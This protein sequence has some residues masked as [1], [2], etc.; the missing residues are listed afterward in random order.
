M[1]KKDK[2]IQ[3]KKEKEAKR[4][5]LL[6]A[7]AKSQLTQEQMN[8]LNSIKDATS[9]KRDRKHSVGNQIEEEVINDNKEEVQ[10]EN[11]NI[12]QVNIFDTV[13]Y[14]NENPIQIQHHESHQKMS[15]AERLE[16][17]AKQLFPDISL[18]SFDQKRIPKGQVQAQPRELIS[19]YDPEK[20]DIYDID[21]Q[22]ITN[23]DSLLTDI[24]S[25]KNQQINRDENIIK[26]RAQ[27]P[28]LI[29]ENDII[30]AI[31]GNLIT[32]ISGETGCGKSTQIPQFLYEAGFT[33][34]GAIAITQPRRLA[35]ISL[36]QRVRDETGFTMGKEISYQVKHECSGID[37]DKMKMK[38][39]TDG[40]LIN[41]MQTSVMVPQYSVIIID[42]AHERKVNIDLL[43][44]VLSRV[45]IARAK[46]N[47]PL[48]LV[49][50]S[51][52]L[53]LDDFLN[54]KLVFPRTLNLI[55]IQTR[56]YP[57]QIYFNKVT[58][59]DYVQAAIEKCVKIHQTLPPGDVLVFLTGQKEIHQCC[60]ILND[61]LRQGIR[62]QNIDQEYSNSEEENQQQL[63]QQENEEEQLQQQQQ[64]LNDDKADYLELKNLV[65]TVQMTQNNVF[66]IDTDLSDY[67]VVPLYSKLDLKNQQIIFHNNPTK[68]RMFVIATNVAE[69]SITIPTIRYVVD[70][71]KQKRKITDTKIGLEKHM[72][73]WISQA[74]A[75]QRSG[76]AGRTGPGYCYRLYSTA[77]YSN[78]FQK[79][80]NP[81]ITQISLD[82]VILQMKSI[83]IKDVYKFPYL[84]SPDIKAIKESL[85]NLIKLG[86]M[87]IKQETNS[88]NSNITQLG[89]ILSQI[90]LSPKYGKFLLQTRIRNL[91]QYGVL[92]VCILSVEEIIN[93]QVFQVHT[94]IQT[95]DN[96]QDEIKQLEQE[97]KEQQQQIKDQ[98]QTYKNLKSFI[99]KHGEGYKISDLIYLM[100]IVGIA[101][102]QIKDDQDIQYQINQLSQQYHFISKSFKEIY[103][104]L[105]QILEILN[106]I[107]EDKTI[108]TECVS[109]IKQY[110]K[111]SREAQLTLAELIVQTN[112]LHKI[113]KLQCKLDQEKNINRYYYTTREYEQ[114][115]IH[116]TSIY[117]GK[118]NCEYISYCQLLTFG[119][120]HSQITTPK[121]Y[122]VNLTEV[123]N[124][125]ILYDLDTRSNQLKKLT[126]Y[127]NSEYYDSKND[128]MM[129]K[130]SAVIENSWVLEDIEIPFP[131]DQLGFYSKFARALYSGQILQFYQIL[132]KYYKYKIADIRESNMQPYSQKIIKALMFNEITNKN[133]LIKK[134]SKD[135]QFLLQECLDF[136]QEAYHQLIKSKWPPIE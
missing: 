93:K 73:G 113:A 12:Q 114:V 33:E 56:Q 57:V 86:A 45:V 31:K 119:E 136:V 96:D 36:A 121:I 99:E 108:V 5:Q 72:I 120:Q 68:K 32:L 126:I 127:E 6:A 78:Q 28:I 48:R 90:P 75:D 11:N 109:A 64:Q 8:Q 53:R 14:E 44:G 122:M 112:G 41:E 81:E 55:K 82:H 104:N 88:D 124:K 54:N 10:Q 43:I 117:Y 51:A 16:I 17:M 47:K 70:A 116:P 49:I 98:F 7:L 66:K 1:N 20:D 69:T 133:D 34:F 100:N 129:C 42:E 4:Q 25:F 103:Y 125:S 9:S 134:W 80:D 135:K 132:Q 107:V 38:F 65:G 24:N 52:T 128:R 63:N 18:E 61:K 39:M 15:E 74:A 58:K 13:V 115:Y 3:E 21:P 23:Y 89:I 97:Q 50:M 118:Q 85:T 60:S 111:P 22:S 131:K 26:Q 76:R 67:V 37:V 29:Q 19:E 46:M 123:P 71:G 102:S 62:K 94:Q 87:K 106:L 105:L 95:N 79:F 27:L 101:I 35:A 110:Q 92:M 77:V 83:G 59:D 84:T 30:D 40:I 2:K 91:L 130:G